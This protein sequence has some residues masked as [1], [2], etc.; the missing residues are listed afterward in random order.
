MKNII[1]LCLILSF[2]TLFAQVGVGTTDP[3]ATLDIEGNPTVTTQTD[4]I[5]PPRISRSA[6]INKTGYGADQEGTIIYVTNL[7][8]VNNAQ[9]NNITKIG[10]YYFDG[11]VWNSM[12]FDKD[13]GDIKQ[14]FQT[15][16]HNGWVLLDGRAVTSLT[17]SQ[18][19]RAI[20]L[21][22]GTNLPDATNAFLV[23]NGTGLGSVSSSNTKTITQANLPN[24]NLPA[25]TTSSD[26]LHSHT[27]NVTNTP[28]NFTLLRLSITGQSVTGEFFD[29]PGSGF[30]PNIFNNTG[31]LT[32][33]DG[34]DHSHSV[35]VSS[36]GSGTGFDITP[37]S[38]SVNTFI[39]LGN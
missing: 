35:N 3:K 15:S 12:T 16:D 9:T 21:G 39:F 2:T 28:G 11:T 22:F 30:E 33:D 31:T 36:G 20:S 14:G 26:G 27:N 19:T 13:Y 32:I 6:L 37:R 18:I 29:Q 7:S 8:G 5:I 25:G 24:Y 17:A 38:L 1:L 4:G 23:Q 34:G 10:Y